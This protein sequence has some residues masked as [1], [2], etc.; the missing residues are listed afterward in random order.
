VDLYCKIYVDGDLDRESLTGRIATIVSGKTEDHSV[1]TDCLEVD[2]RTNEDCDPRRFSP[3]WNGFVHA[4][5]YLD[6]EPKAGCEHGA[7]VSAVSRLLEGLWAS[8]LK[9]IA[10]ADFESELPRSGG[11]ASA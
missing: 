11:L 7:Y 8:G 6:V 10:A 5:Y 4:G 2:V 1:S 9:A 3:D